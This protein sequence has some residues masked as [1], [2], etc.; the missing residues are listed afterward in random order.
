MNTDNTII[1]GLIISNGLVAMSGA[2]IAQSQALQM[3]RWVS[4]R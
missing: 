2:L 3:S 4:D 1:I